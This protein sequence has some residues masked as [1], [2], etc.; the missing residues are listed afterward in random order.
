LELEPRFGFVAA[1]AANCH[2]LNVIMGFAVDPHFERNEAIRLA[3]L[4]LSIDDGDPDTLAFA[5]G[6]SAYLVGDFES[7]IEMANRAVALNP[8]SYNAWHC[9]GYVYSAAGLPEEAIQSFERALRMS[10]A[11]PSLHMLFVGVAWASIEL[12]RFDEA[13]VAGK[14][15]LRQNSS[16]SVAYRCLA[17]A[18]AHLGR[19]AEA[20]EAAARLLEADPAFTISARIGRRGAKLVKEGLWKAGL[21]E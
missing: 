12:G 14:K 3:R 4:A 17:S 8:N 11:D 7:A 2:T 18:L 21:P 1:L 6:V 5:A 16:F 10:P 19:D 13:V 20:R 15:A 9:R